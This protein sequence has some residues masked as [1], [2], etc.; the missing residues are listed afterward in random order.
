[1]F[2]LLRAGEF[3]DRFQIPGSTP[4]KMNR[5]PFTV[6]V[7]CSA[8]L[9]LAQP[10]AKFY[11]PLPLV[12]KIKAV[13]TSEVD[14]GD[15]KS[16]FDG[17]EK[18]FFRTHGVNPA[19]VR[20]EFKEPIAYEAMRFV[21]S[22]DLYEFSVATADSMDDLRAKHGSYSLLIKDRRTS[23]NGRSEMIF[24]KPQTVRAM[25]LDLHRLTG[26]DY[27]HVFEWQLCVPGK[28]S[29]LRLFRVL[30]RRDPSKVEELNGTVSVPEDTVLCLKV[31]G[32]VNGKEV[33]LS[34]DVRWTNA[35][36]GVAKV[37]TENGEFAVMSPK[38][39]ELYVFAGSE[40]RGLAIVPTSRTLK[41]RDP[42]IEV[43]YIERLPRIPY[44]GPNGGLPMPGS[45][46]TWRAHLWN[47]GVS[48]VSIKGIWMLDG[49]QVSS[50]G[51]VLQ[52]MTDTLVDLP[53]QWD[54]ARHELTMTI[55]PDRPLKQVTTTG[56]SLTVDTNALAVG[57]WVERSLWD[58]MHEHQRELPTGDAN[59]FA[60]W[61]Q[62]LIRKWN[63]M[64]EEAK[65]KE[66]PNG[67]TER[68]RLDRLVVVP[69]F[70][71]PLAG[72]L[73]S[74]NPDNRDKTCDIV[75]GFEGSEVAPGKAVDDKAWW[76][77]EKAVQALKDGD[78]ASHKQ[79]PAFWCGLGYIHEMN[80]ARYLVDSYGFDVHTDVGKDPAKWNIKVTDEKG[81]ILGRYIPMKELV[82]SQKFVGIMG[83]DYW[84]FS[85][86][87][88]M[89]W[90]RVLGKRARGG[91][92]NAP[93]TIGEF[94][95]DVPKRVVLQFFDTSGQA[96]DGAEVSVYR[97][98]GT[99]SDWYTKVFED[100]VALKATCDS[101]GKAVFDRTL[102]SEN[103]HIQHDFGVSQA[104]A[105]LCV[106]YRGE[107]YYLFECVGDANIAY[108]LGMKDAVVLKRQIRLR[109]GDPSPD[110]WDAHATWEVP[111]TGFSQKASG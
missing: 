33:D 94:L 75:W 91:T 53:W 27:V 55:T 47:W 14:L 84:K 31:R 15:P 106:K 41:N 26:D 45:A 70:A 44:D 5:L 86:F 63:Q 107:R 49:R 42:D 35:S 72:G 6:F 87:E 56:N 98:H 82:W 10:Q 13:E 71:L 90:N 95:D 60:G 111:G 65:Y 43:Q 78:V 80:H 20:V 88:A 74:N 36:L 34:D 3:P 81:P 46:T 73:P 99:G 11:V 62:R 29:R 93:S 92:Y 39:H 57:F 38:Y 12:D 105:L 8:S 100:K 67:I 52:P 77:P 9:A 40:T 59:S 66:F 109:T 83:G 48:P 54:A 110:E 79:F 97:A 64:F 32:L 76:S 25:E 18:T 102:W 16:A 2:A 17:D 85:A 61:G 24:A 1:M 103:G 23:Q 68:V 101:E 7:L 51:L 50:C 104:V 30:D 37:G 108:N 69:D 4:Q 22:E 58:F 19:F 89:C 21:F 28:V 96:L